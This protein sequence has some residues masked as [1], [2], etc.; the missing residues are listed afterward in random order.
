M[1]KN[2][3]WFRAVAIFWTYSQT[4]EKIILDRSEAILKSAPYPFK[5]PGIWNEHPNGEF[6]IQFNQNRPRNF[7][8]SKK[9][10]GKKVTFPV[11]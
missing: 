10:A 7:F 8:W 3:F 6:G 5:A 11:H 1:A 2:N 9:F 4:Q